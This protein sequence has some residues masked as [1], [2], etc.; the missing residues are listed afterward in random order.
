MIVGE[1][2]ADRSTPSALGSHLGMDKQAS[3]D[4][5]SLFTSAAATTS[6]ITG[7]AWVFFILAGI[8]VATAF[9]QLYERIF[10]P[11]DR[12]ARDMPRKLIWLAVFVGSSFGAGVAWP[13]LR[14]AGGPVL[15]GVIVLVALTGFWWFT[16]WFVLAGRIGQDTV[17]W[18]AP[19]RRAAAGVRGRWRRLT[20]P[21]RSGGGGRCLMRLLPVRRRH[22]WMRGAPGRGTRAAG[23]GTGSGPSWGRW[24][25]PSR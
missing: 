5:A 19:A 24:R 3:A 14:G 11:E 16:M 10:E 13:G 4:V 23:S 1:A 20:I 7:T 17:R 6:V 8:A 9:Q 15:L 12:G 21:R 2:L 22:G 25:R 18:R